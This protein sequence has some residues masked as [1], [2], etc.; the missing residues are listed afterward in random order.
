MSDLKVEEVTNAPKSTKIN[1]PTNLSSVQSKKLPAQTE[2]H[3][4]IETGIKNFVCV[5][6]FHF[7]VLKF[8]WRNKGQR[9]FWLLGGPRIIA[10]YVNYI[11]A[12]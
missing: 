9:P 1:L 8:R 11:I 5:F 12:R 10:H 6:Q 4:K 2:Q 7:E 3:V